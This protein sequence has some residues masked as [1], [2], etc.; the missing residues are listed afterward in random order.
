MTIVVKL[1]ITIEA[2]N[3]EQKY[4]SK[5]ENP[6]CELAFLGGS[7]YLEHITIQK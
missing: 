3:G 5:H 1:S 4:Y 7:G 2:E 6:R